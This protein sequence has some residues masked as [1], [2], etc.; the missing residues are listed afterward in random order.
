MLAQSLTGSLLAFAV[1]R[2]HFHRKRHLTKGCAGT[3]DCV[4]HLLGFFHGFI[5]FILQQDENLC[6]KNGTCYIHFLF[7]TKERTP[8]V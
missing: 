1:Q 8:W 2:N 3:A 4:T 7:I 6:L 5:G